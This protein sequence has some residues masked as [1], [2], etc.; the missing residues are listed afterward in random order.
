MSGN[1]ALNAGGQLNLG[2][3]TSTPI[4][5][6]TPR[7]STLRLANTALSTVYCFGADERAALAFIHH[8]H[9]IPGAADFKRTEVQPDSEVAACGSTLRQR[10]AIE[11]VC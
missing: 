6:A 4:S 7:Y 3:C 8:V 11:T 9:A 10:S 2:I 5:I 1:A